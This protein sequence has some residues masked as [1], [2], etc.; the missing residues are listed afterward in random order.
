MFVNNSEVFCEAGLHVSINPKSCV[1]SATAW[2]RAKTW[3]ELRLGK[4]V[5]GGG[6]RT[7][8]VPTNVT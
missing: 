4:G 3:T 8:K 5:G 6:N 2:N 7:K 1:D